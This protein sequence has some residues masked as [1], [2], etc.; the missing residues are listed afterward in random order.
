[1]GAPVR[2]RVRGWWLA[3]AVGALVAVVLLAGDRS[4]SCAEYADSPGVCTSV[5][6]DP[7]TWILVGIGVLVIIGALYRALRRR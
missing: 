3:I 1:M 6:E 5:D 4:G 7:R 2:R